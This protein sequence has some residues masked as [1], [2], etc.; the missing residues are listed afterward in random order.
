MQYRFTS[1]IVFSLAILLTLS[2]TPGA[3]AQ[4]L[5]FSDA[6]G[7]RIEMPGKAKRIVSLSPALTEILYAAG[8]GSSV[9]GVTTYCTYPA[10]AKTKAKIG[11]YSAKSVSME[12]IIALAPDLVVGE[13]RMHGALAG[14][15][16]KTG[17]V[18]AVFRLASFE[19]IYAALG[20]FGEIAGDRDS[21]SRTVDTMKRRIDA[22]SAKT[23]LIPRNERPSVFWEVWDDPLMSAGPA[24]FTSMIIELAGGRNVFSDAKQDWPIVSFEE[25]VKRNPSVIMSA[26][27][28][29]DKVTPERLASRPGWASLS[30]V[31]GKRVL[32]LDGD[33]SSRPTPRLL[34]AAELIAKYLDSVK[35]V[36]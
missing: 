4:G 15:L 17:L 25:I 18:T 26:D 30:A 33:T 7:T 1:F 19:D 14:Q 35:G 36:K 3:G 31:K 16:A 28:H 32:L 12:S 23:A 2:V 21:A 27:T 24:T 22:L 8:A 13:L 10:E 29:G 11:G 20:K 5:A 6:S 34:D 9:V